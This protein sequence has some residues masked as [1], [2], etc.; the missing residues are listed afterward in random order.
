MTK[1]YLAVVQG[2]TPREGEMRDLLFRD[3]AKNKSYV[4]KRMRKGV[5]EALLRYETL[6]QLPGFSLVRVELLTGRS[7]QIRVQFASRGFPLL[8]DGRY[9]GARRE[10][11]LA[12]YSAELSF[13]HPLS[14]ELLQFSSPPP[15]EE[16]WSWFSR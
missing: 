8:G 10:L 6:Q 1:R 7:H 4:V 15:E 3:R 2:T 11:P 12:L 14:G 16:P 13:P 5:R 9:G